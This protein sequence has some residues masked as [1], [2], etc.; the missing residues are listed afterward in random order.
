VTLDLVVSAEGK[1]LSAALIEGSPELGELARATA[2]AW[3]FEPARRADTPVSAKIRVR[4][5]F[6]RRAPTPPPIAEHPVPAPP[7]FA[8][9]PPATPA[10]SA[11]APNAEPAE[12]F[13]H[14]ARSGHAPKPIEPHV[15]LLATEVREVPG[16][17]GDAFRA[18][19][20]MPGVTPIVS[21]VPY[22]I[23]R[24]APPGD[25]GFFIDGVRVPSLFHFGAGQAV[26][27][28]GLVQAVDFYPGA[29]PARFGRF[30]GGI[31]SGDTVPPADHVRGEA[32][33]RVLDAGGL[34]EIPFA[35]GHGDALVSGR[36]GYPGLLLSI[37]DPD[38]GL[39]YWDYQARLRYRW[40]S[41]ARVEAFAFG[42]F[43]SLSS[44]DNGGPMKQLLG[45]TFGRFRLS[46]AQ[47]TGASSE[48]RIDAIGGWDRTDVDTSLSLSSQTYSLAG[49]W[50]AHP[51]ERTSVRAGADVSLEPYRFG[52]TDVGS[53]GD[54]VFNSTLPT[55]QNDLNFG[56]YGEVSTRLS[57]R[58]STD[59]GLRADLFT[60][61]YP[62]QSPANE[63][64]RARQIAALDPRLTVRFAL[65]DSVT[66][67]SAL[68]I[69]HQASNIPIPIPALAFSQL[70]RGL[71]T[72]Y[73][74]SEGVEAQ[75]PLGFTGSATVY[76]NALTGLAQ[77]TNDCPNAAS[78]CNDETVNGRSAGLELLIRRSLT[79]RLSGWLSYTF[80]RTERDSYD[81][82]SGTWGHRLGEF[83]RPHVLNLMGAYDLGA[84]WRAGARLVAYSGIPYS[85][86]S[87]DGTPNARTPPFYRFD[88]RL[89]KR[90]KKPWGHV[91]FI[92]EWLNVLL[93]KE[94]IGVTCAGIGPNACAPESIGPI[95]VPSLGV[96]VV[97]R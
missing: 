84:D 48:L 65:S 78:A 63:A 79:E 36:Y 37:A 15:R 75:L 16:A 7:P 77:L 47:P 97:Y 38:V 93:T 43:D 14:G 62:G 25:T 40:D 46:Y 19:E 42:S 72:A 66:W 94:Q 4:V 86:S 69:A 18:I 28:P 60:A 12:V 80:S 81:G 1:V 34:L 51:D 5:T 45:L 3:T 23:V 13:V 83:D 85:T 32:N 33:V 82:Q 53:G 91:S 70:G 61:S 21:G 6:E 88:V 2:L 35:N 73:Q 92:A 90:W 74:A 22:F 17:F 44:R 52:G 41:G 8:S 11:P 87:E 59:L 24:G 96:E 9:A 55:A 39:G 30:V 89:E 76:L 10:P 64:T 67:T 54:G 20:M 50:I 57:R 29:S 26:I 27:H 95:T 68:G 49:T 31:L 71:Q 56:L 58:V